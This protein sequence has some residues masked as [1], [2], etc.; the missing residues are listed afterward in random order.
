M[1]LIGAIQA[2]SQ[3]P[4]AKRNED[5]DVFV[6]FL[7]ILEDVSLCQPL[8]SG[9]VDTNDQFSQIMHQTVVDYHAAS[10]MSQVLKKVVDTQIENQSMTER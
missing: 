6:D 9:L 1:K 7:T 4:S 3:T 2:L 10:L 8:I 5:A